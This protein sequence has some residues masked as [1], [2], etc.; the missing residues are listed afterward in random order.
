VSLHY[1]PPQFSVVRLSTCRHCFR[2]IEDRQVLG[3]LHVE[4]LFSC[5]VPKNGTDPKQWKHAEPVD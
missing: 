4:G 2:T 3:W 1:V 5:G